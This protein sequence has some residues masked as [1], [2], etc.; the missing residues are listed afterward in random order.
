[1]R[2]GLIWLCALLFL[3]WSYEGAGRGREAVSEDVGFRLWTG[4]Q[5]RDACCVSP[6]CL[7]DRSFC[8]CTCE[9]IHTYDC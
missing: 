4:G 5:F 9:C 7:H 2:T 8:L 1:M 6:L 3:G